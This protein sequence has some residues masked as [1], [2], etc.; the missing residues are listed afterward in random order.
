RLETL[1][2]YL[3]AMAVK[4][5]ADYAEHLAVVMQ[6]IKRLNA[7]RRKSDYLHINVELEEDTVDETTDESEI[8]LGA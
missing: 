7:T 4:T 2:D 5:P 8:A 6:I 1:V 3:E